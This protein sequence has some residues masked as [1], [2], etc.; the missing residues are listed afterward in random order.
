MWQGLMDVIVTRKMQLSFKTNY[1]KVSVIDDSVKIGLNEKR[2]GLIAT[3]PDGTPIPF[4]KQITVNSKAGHLMTATIE[5]IVSI[6]NIEEWNEVLQKEVVVQHTI[7]GDEL[8][9]IMNRAMK[10]QER[11]F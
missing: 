3:M 7:N 4:I 10:T 9:G 1:M 11:S 8:V 5:L 2:M 6:K